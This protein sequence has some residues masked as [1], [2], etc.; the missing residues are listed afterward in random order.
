MERIDMQKRIYFKNEGQKIEGIL[1]LPNK[2]TQFLVMIV[3]GFSQTM[4]G[5]NDAFIKLAEELVLKGIAILRFNFRYTTE[6]Y[7]E[8]YKMTISGEVSDLKKIIGE[9]SKKYQKIGLLGESMGGAISLL[10][11]DERISCLVLWYPGINLKDENFTQE[12]KK[13][14]KKAEKIGYAIHHKTTRNI[15]IKVGF[16]FIKEITNTNVSPRLKKVKCPL[17]IIQGDKDTVCLL[18]NVKKAFK[19]AN[20][21]KKFEIIKGTEHGWNDENDQPNSKLQEKAI[22]LTIDW[23]KKW[24]K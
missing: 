3:P 24:L 8:F 14:V 22:K 9:M 23:F 13:E 18:D 19:L 12:W 7:T 6:D 17:L 5:P 1:H 11:Y 21:P 20:Q 2:P 15:D 10:S 16:K 4:N